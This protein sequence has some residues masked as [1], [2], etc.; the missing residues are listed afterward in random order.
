MCFQIVDD[1]LDV[2]ASDAELG[3]PAGQDLLEGVYTLPVIYAL[4]ES[5][6]LR[7][8]LGRP[9]DADRL[10]EVRAIATSNGAVDAAL[11]VA[12]DHAAKAA[13]RSPARRASTP[14]C[15]PSSAA[16]STASSPASADRRDRA[17]TTAAAIARDLER[18]PFQMTRVHGRSAHHGRYTPSI[19][20]VV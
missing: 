4:R 13:R 2:T 8:L 5:P 17:S 11:G 7:E 6:E 12:R 18:F 19:A 14:R 16:S 1:V 3:K 9:L 15:A 20:R 10:A